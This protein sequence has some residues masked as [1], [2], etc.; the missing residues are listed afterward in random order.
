[1]W[2]EVKVEGEGAGRE[3]GRRQEVDKVNNKDNNVNVRL[4][5]AIRLIKK[6]H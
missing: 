6:N 4:T 2:V 3:R 5:T 1:M